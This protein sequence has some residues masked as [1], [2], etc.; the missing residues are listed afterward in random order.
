M[1]SWAFYSDFNFWRTELDWWTAVQTFVAKVI[2]GPSIISCYIFVTGARQVSSKR[3]KWQ[4]VELVL[5]SLGIYH[6]FCRIENNNWESVCACIG[7]SNSLHQLWHCEVYSAEWIRPEDGW[8][9]DWE[10]SQSIVKTNGERL[11]HVASRGRPVDRQGRISL[12]MEQRS[13]S[14]QNCCSCCN[15][16]IICSRSPIAGLQ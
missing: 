4:S 5:R 3:G 11:N 9:N 12:S 1:S 15:L 13:R 16:N 14:S 2:G 10:M 8:H 6:P 7:V